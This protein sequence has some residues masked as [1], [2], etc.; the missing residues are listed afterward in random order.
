MHAP[1]IPSDRSRNRRPDADGWGP[2]RFSHTLNGLS[3][4]TQSLVRIAS[5]RFDWENELR[6]CAF[7]CRRTLVDSNYLHALARCVAPNRALRCG[8]GEGRDIGMALSGMARR[9]VSQGGA[10]GR[11]LEYSLARL[12]SIELNGSFY[13]LQRPHSYLDW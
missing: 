2:T 9:L 7:R 1:A 8:A 6:R 10:Q 12:N 13:S 5:A 3:D 4:P 11:E